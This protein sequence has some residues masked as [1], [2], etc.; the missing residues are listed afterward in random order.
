MIS[1]NGCAWNTSCLKIFEAVLSLGNSKKFCLNCRQ[2]FQD[3]F[4]EMLVLLGFG[5]NHFSQGQLGM[6]VAYT[7]LCQS[8]WHCRIL[9]E[10]FCCTS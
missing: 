4:T 10:G 9:L 2:S 7:Y 1:Q 8:N 5:R 6:R 3:V